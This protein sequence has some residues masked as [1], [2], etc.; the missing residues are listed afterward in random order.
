M[1]V[2]V[3]G[4]GGPGQGGVGM[5]PTHL[6]LGHRDGFPSFRSSEAGHAHTGIITFHE[7]GLAPC[8]L[9]QLQ[10]HFSSLTLIPLLIELERE[11]TLQLV[12]LLVLQLELLL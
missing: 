5:H 12:L 2:C 8:V 4:I 6:C 11:L 1:D 9:I 7:E 10:H 3:C